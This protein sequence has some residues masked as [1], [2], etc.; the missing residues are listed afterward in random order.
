MSITDDIKAAMKE[1][2]AERKGGSK[3][4]AIY[5]LNRWL[6]EERRRLNE[7]YA[8][9]KSQIEAQEDIPSDSV[10]DAVL[11]MVAQAVRQGESRSSLRIALGKQSL[12]E[13]D[14][15]IEVALERLGDKVE[16][17]EAEL[18]SLTENGEHSRGY[19]FFDV[20]VNATGGRYTGVYMTG[21]KRHHLK[22]QPAPAG[23]KEI[24][25]EL[26]DLGVG[27]EIAKREGLA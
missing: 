1:W 5:D 26:W 23:S 21:P 8:E 2:R 24:L 17:G 7:E 27:A 6:G 18:F 25:D 10:P 20:V 12:A 15:L 16:S 13:V 9:R 19:T 22:I 3:G 4:Q 14:P 11:D